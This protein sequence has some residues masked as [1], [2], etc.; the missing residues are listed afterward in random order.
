MATKGGTGVFR[1]DFNGGPEMLIKAMKEMASNEVLVGFPE[2]STDRKADP[3]D[4]SGKDLTNAQLGYIHDNGAPEANIPARPFMLPGIEAARSKLIKIA[5]STGLKALD[6]DNPQETVDQG[7]HMMGLVAQA[8]IRGVIN[9][10]I[11]P[12][13]ADRTLR[14][15]ARRGRKGAQEELDNRAKGLPQGK[16]LAK[17]LIDTGQLRNA[18]NYVIRSR[19][20][21][22]K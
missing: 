16:E 6:S 21:R 3:E 4:E 11:D 7:L 2:A 10:G 22:S 5:R 1:K 17:P 20:R 14:E 15:R 9:D 8:S 13:L 19:K 12:P 18:V